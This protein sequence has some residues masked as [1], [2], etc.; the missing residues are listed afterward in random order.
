MHGRTL[1]QRCSAGNNG[2]VQRHLIQQ[3]KGRKIARTDQ[4]NTRR[5][6]ARSK[7]FAPFFAYSPQGKKKTQQANKESKS[8]KKDKLRTTKAK[9]LKIGKEEKQRAKG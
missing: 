3:P 7:T 5:E 8:K 2:N 4:P 9:P 1:L 6:D